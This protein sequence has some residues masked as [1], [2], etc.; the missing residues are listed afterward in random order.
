MRATQAVPGDART[1]ARG[2]AVLG[3]LLL[4]LCAGCGGSSATS[5]ATTG[6]QTGVT[7]LSTADQLGT[8]DAVSDLGG[9]GDTS[10]P[11]GGGPACYG[12]DS[13]YPTFDRQCG[14][15]AE[16][17]IG[18]HATSCCGSM[19]AMG[20]RTSEKGR[21]DALEPICQAQLPLCG[22][23]SESLELDDGTT[24]IDQSNAVQ[25]ECRNQL[26]TTF[27]P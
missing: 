27:L 5:D 2:R 8:S 10:S 4:L 25:V 15:D 23:F 22:C 12:P 18:L 3:A 16:C 9:M 6:D 19:Y 26:C 7:D 20:I 17:A 14:S 1:A 11:D 13:E 21:F 24:T